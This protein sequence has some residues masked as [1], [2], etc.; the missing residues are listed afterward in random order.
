MVKESDF[1][2]NIKKARND[3][4]K[5][6]NKLK[7]TQIGVGENRKVK[8]TTIKEET[9]IKTTIIELKGTSQYSRKGTY[10]K[11]IFPKGTI[12]NRKTI[13]RYTK[14]IEGTEPARQIK[15]IQRYYEEKAKGTT[16]IKKLREYLKNKGLLEKKKPIFKP[17]RTLRGAVIEGQKALKQGSYNSIENKTLEGL[18]HNIKQAY[19][20]LLFN[21]VKGNTKKEKWKIVND[22]IKDPTG[23]RKNLS[24]VIKLL[25]TPTN[26]KG[27]EITELGVITDTNKTLE[28]IIANYKKLQTEQIGK[29]GKYLMFIQPYKESEAETNLKNKTNTNGTTK[30]NKAGTIKQIKIDILIT[31]E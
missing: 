11:T 18:E 26:S 15:T 14:A 30:I 29:K 25:G 28:E 16:P 5:I 27:N 12:G 17:Q 13:T 23:I 31:N 8:T 24:Y 4:W 10:V 2:K 6:K 7:G 3:F 20:E 19:Q 22:I 9:G 21:V 1:V